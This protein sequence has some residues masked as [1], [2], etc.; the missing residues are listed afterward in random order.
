MIFDTIIIFILVNC[1]L[2]ILI[3]MSA[4]HIVAVPQDTEDEDGT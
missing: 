1:H 4:C 3:L 2:V